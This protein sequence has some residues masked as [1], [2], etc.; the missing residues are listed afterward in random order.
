M[1]N[2]LEQQ[3]KKCLRESQTLTNDLMNLLANFQASTSQP[4]TLILDTFHDAN[5]TNLSAHTPNQSPMGS[6]W[7]RLVGEFDINSNVLT[8]A[9]SN[10]SYQID[11]GQSYVTIAVDVDLSTGDTEVDLYGAAT[12]NGSTYMQ[13]YIQVAA[14]IITLT[15]TGTTV[16]TASHTFSNGPQT[17]S[18]VI[19]ATGLEF[20][21]DGTTIVSYSGSIPSTGTYTALQTAGTAVS[22]FSQFLVTQP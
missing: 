9:Q 16:A 7:Q 1:P 6:S 4:T 12:V 17:W 18:F 13:A 5:G 19:S 8:S 20:Q 10:N 21:I 14:G 11:S 2:N 3:I 22:T 15:N